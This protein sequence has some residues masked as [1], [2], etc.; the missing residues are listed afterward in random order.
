MSSVLNH[1][2]IKHG[3][4]GDFTACA[5]IRPANS[6]KQKSTGIICPQPSCGGEIIERKSRRGKV[7]FGCNVILLRLRVWNRPLT[8]ALPEV[9]LS[10]PDH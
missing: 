5:T 1:L 3:R 9:R 7:F 2:V 8:E 6:F 4:F 10:L